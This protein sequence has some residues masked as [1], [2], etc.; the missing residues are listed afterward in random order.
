[1]TEDELQAL[2]RLQKVA[3]PYFKGAALTQQMA[4]ALPAVVSAVPS[5]VAE[6]RR[7][8]ALVE[9]AYREGWKEMEFRD[10]YDDPRFLE[11]DW[12][13]SAARKALEGGV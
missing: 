6:V 4:Q 2:E 7:L 10:S 1:M 12:S 5:L 9:A 8:R 11:Y 3:A 13:E